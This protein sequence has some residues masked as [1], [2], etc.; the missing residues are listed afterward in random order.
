[1]TR[2]RTIRRLYAFATVPIIAVGLSIA[3][4]GYGQAQEGGSF[5]ADLAVL[6]DS[7]ATGSATATLDGTTITVEIQSSGLLAGAPHAQHLHIGGTNTCPDASADA[8]GDGLISTSEGLPSYGPIMVSL[9]IE[10]DVS[11][12]SGLAVDRFPVAEDDGSLSYSRTFELPDGV[13]PEMIADAVVVQHGVDLNDSGEYDGEEMSELDP[14]LPLE[15]T[16]PANCGPHTATGAGGGDAA[17]TAAATQPTAAAG[18]TVP[19]TGA[20]PGSGPGTTMLILVG[21][22]LALA[23]GSFGYAMRHQAVPK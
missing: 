8:D 11:D 10:G 14:N 5:T 17:P 6:N 16:L 15:A 21:G 12:A 4:V 18:V 7:G 20:G 22:L 2:G 23:V 3:A 9:T 1:M 13:T 19:D